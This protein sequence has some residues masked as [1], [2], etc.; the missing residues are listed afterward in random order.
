[1][2]LGPLFVVSV[3]LDTAFANSAFHYCGGRVVDIVTR[4]SSENTQVRLEGL[5]GWAKLGY[6]RSEYAPMRHR[7][8]TMLLAAYLADQAVLLEFVNRSGGP[9]QC[10]DVHGFEDEIRYVRL[11]N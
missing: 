9:Q 4:S 3:L 7:Q 8:F 2:I 1:M 5:N 10:N 6:G 11:R